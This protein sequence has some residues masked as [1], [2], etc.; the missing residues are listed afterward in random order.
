MYY[1]RSKKP[2]VIAILV[3][4]LVI[5]LTSAFSMTMSA[6]KEKE[7]L[8]ETRAE[9]SPAEQTETG[10]T[11]PDAGRHK[12]VVYNSGLCSVTVI[13]GNSIGMDK[14]KTIYEVVEDEDVELSVV[15]LSTESFLDAEVLD[16]NGDDIPR[17]V[18]RKDDG[19]AEI[20]FVMPGA[21][22]FVNLS[23]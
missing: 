13:G 11:A 20:G 19:T 10:S 21:S 15:P 3:F 23:F 2:L 4:I 17:S 9:I 1:R 18:K 14:A 5:G 22:V 7:S 16:G 12:L 6:E 8:P